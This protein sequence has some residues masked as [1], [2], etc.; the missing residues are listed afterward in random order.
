VCIINYSNFLISF[1]FQA[2]PFPIQ[3]PS[4]IPLPSSLVCKLCIDTRKVLNNGRGRDRGRVKVVAIS[5][6]TDAAIQITVFAV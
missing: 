5:A 1:I 6:V 2:G 4:Y 3:N